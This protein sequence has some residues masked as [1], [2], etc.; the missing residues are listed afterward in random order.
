M[1]AILF[2]RFCHSSGPHVRGNRSGCGL[3]PP[4]Y[5]SAGTRWASL[6]TRRTTAFVDASACRGSCVGATVAWAMRGRTWRRTSRM[7]GRNCI[8]DRRDKLSSVGRG[9]A[10]EP[11]HAVIQMDLTWRGVCICDRLPILNTSYFD[12]MAGLGL[13]VQGYLVPLPKFFSPSHRMFGH[14]YKVLN[15]NEKITNYTYCD[16]F[17][18]QMFLSLISPSFD[19]VVLQ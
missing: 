14:M 6:D 1:W 16:K 17:T 5:T 13:I 19:N 3:S 2:R 8:R 7:W 10:P 15:V 18:R 11:S 12:R 4:A 9:L